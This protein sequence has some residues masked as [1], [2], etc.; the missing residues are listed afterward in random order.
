MTEEVVS[1]VDAALVLTDHE[2]TDYGML[3]DVGFV[4]DTRNCV[5]PG[6]NVQLL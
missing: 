5:P 1:S 6:P 2:D 3:A 4:L